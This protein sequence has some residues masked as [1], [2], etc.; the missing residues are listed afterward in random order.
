MKSKLQGVSIA[1]EKAFTDSWPFFVMLTAFIVAIYVSSLASVPSLRAVERLIPFTFLCVLHAGLNWGAIILTDR[2]G[3]VL[4]YLILQGVIIFAITILSENRG[5]VIVLYMAMSGMAVGI[6]DDFKS[7][8]LAVLGYMAL[9]GV[10][11][12]LVWG[13]ASFQVFIVTYISM[14]MFVFIFVTLYTRQSRERAKA[15]RLLGELEEAHDRLNEYAAQVEDLTLAAE[16]QRMA[17]ELHDTLAQG[18]AGL[19]L[20]LEA[21]DSRLTKGQVEAAG[22][23]VQQAMERARTTLAEARRAIADLRSEG[24]IEGDLVG[25]VCKEVERFRSAT[26]IN[27][28]TAYQPLPEIPASIREHALRAI[29]E[30]L[31]NIAQHAQAAN[32]NLHIEVRDHALEVLLKDDGMGFAPEQLDDRSGHY[33]LIG[34]RERARMVGGSLNVESKPGEGTIMVLRIPINGGPT[35]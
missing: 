14:G 2:R 19:I 7:S 32:V 35:S 31:T 25:S 1:D 8:A 17:R 30:G 5:L 4:P 22:G 29:S 28:S 33:G 10:N 15:N 26:G 20:Q 9:A 24:V 13:W 34:L 23:I 21:V 12:Y 27:V 3:W 16:R 6:L 11:Q 18:L